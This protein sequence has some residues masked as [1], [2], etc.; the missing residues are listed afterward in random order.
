[1][2]A[3]SVEQ[4]L[5]QFARVWLGP[6]LFTSTLAGR[7]TLAPLQRSAFLCHPRRRV[8]FKDDDAGV[9]GDTS[10]KAGER[11]EGDTRHDDLVELDLRE[12]VREELERREE[13]RRARHERDAE[14]DERHVAEEEARLQ[15][16]EGLVLE[17]RAV[18]V[19][20]V[21]KHIQAR[22]RRGQERAPPPAVVLGAQRVVGTWVF[23]DVR[24]LTLS[25][26]RSPG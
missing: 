13:A 8:Q 5:H 26:T 20:R 17:V 22:R 1:M 23:D 12:D 19:G 6:G 24:L 3:V 16:V 10:Y 15:N 21:P 2:L 11:G 18:V 9:E 7:K 4:L 25:Q 14:R